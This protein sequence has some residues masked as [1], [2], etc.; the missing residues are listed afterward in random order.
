MGVAFLF[1]RS[2]SV[3][4]RESLTLRSSLQAKNVMTETIT[5]IYR[6]GVLHPL[7]ALNLQEHQTVQLQLLESAPVATSSILLGQL[8]ASGFVT[9]AAHSSQNAVSD[10]DLEALVKTLPITETPA[11]QTLIEDR[12]E[13]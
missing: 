2:R 11:S 9:I 6:E 4:N 7:N 8:R 12:G 10:E 5:A 13:W 1:W 3:S